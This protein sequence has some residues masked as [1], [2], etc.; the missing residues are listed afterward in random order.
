MSKQAINT[1]E[2][3]LGESVRYTV[4]FA[5]YLDP[6][7]RIIGVVSISVLPSSGAPTVSEIG[8]ARD[9]KSISF[10]LSGATLVR[11]FALTFTVTTQ[12]GATQDT[13]KASGALQVVA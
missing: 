12:E 7:E 6:A 10:R 4:D 11:L 5:Q 13:V 1:I 2:L 9:G 8:Y 3:G